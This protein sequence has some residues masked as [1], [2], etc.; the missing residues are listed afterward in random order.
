MQKNKKIIIA[1]IVIIIVAFASLILLLNVSKKSETYSITYIVNNQILLVQSQED[2][3]EPLAPEKEG[4]KFIGWYYNNKKYNF[5]QQ[6]NEDITLEARYEKKQ[7]ET[8][9]IAIEING[10]KYNYQTTEDGILTNIKTPEKEGY[11]FI[12]WYEGENLIDITLPFTKNSTITAKF[13][14]NEKKLESSDNKGK[15]NG[16]NLEDNKDKIPTDK[17]NEEDKKETEQEVK[18]YKVKFIVD[19]KI[20]KEEIVKNG[21]TISIPE[22]PTKQGYTFNGWYYE[23]KKISSNIKVTNDI[24]IIA[25]WDIYTYTIELINDDVFSINRLVYVYKNN[26]KITAKSIYGNYNNI[27][28]YK[29]GTYSTTYKYLK[30]I[31]FE[32]F[33]KSKNYVVEL[34]DGNKV[35]INEN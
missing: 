13:I 24:S 5:S 9:Q 12:G 21:E 8:Y 4:Y 35:Y 22:S 30:I 26:E 34:E 2:I 17:L 6:L 27:N 10:K 16:T 15:N 1:I 11:T 18:K 33:K 28:E 25:K 7:K 19:N 3:K 20:V 29:L 31:S 14:K 32:Q 23:G